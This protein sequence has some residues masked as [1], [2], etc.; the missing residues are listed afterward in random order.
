MLD[1]ALN[2]SVLQ[3]SKRDKTEMNQV[4]LLALSLAQQQHGFRL[5]HQYTV[6][7]HSPK[8]SLDDLYHRL[9]FQQRP[10]TAKQPETGRVKSQYTDKL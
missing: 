2:A 7:S 1:V 6:I 8:S 10:N 3:E 4:Y 5:S 9:G